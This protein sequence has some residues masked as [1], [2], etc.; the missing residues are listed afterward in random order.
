[1]NSNYFSKSSFTCLHFFS[2]RIGLVLGAVTVAA[3]D[4]L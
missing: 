3:V 4:Y 2:L 1:M